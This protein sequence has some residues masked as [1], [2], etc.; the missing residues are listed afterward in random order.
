VEAV[1]VLQVELA[2]ERIHR[3]RAEF[4]VR[5]AYREEQR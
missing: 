4:L 1:E 3:E 5:T 2:A